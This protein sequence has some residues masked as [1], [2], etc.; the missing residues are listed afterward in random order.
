M[1][2]PADNLNWLLERL[3]STV[4]GIRQAVVVSS[5]GL[6]MAKSE[7]VDRETAER[8][9]AALG[10]EIPRAARRRWRR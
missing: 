3:C 7:G 10:I 6:A 8:L 5:D 1:T 4:P 9:A 2:N